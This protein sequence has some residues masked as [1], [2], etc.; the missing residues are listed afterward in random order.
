MTQC[1]G[2]IPFLA[3]MPERRYNKEKEPDGE[4]SD[5]NER[6]GLWA[7]FTESRAFLPCA[8][9]A[10][11]ILAGGVSVLYRLSLQFASDTLGH[12]LTFI[13]KNAGWTAVWFLVLIA[14]AGLTSLLVRRQPLIGGSGIPQLECELHGKIKSSWISVLLCKFAGGFLCMLGGLSL[15][16]EGPSIQ[17][18]AM[19]GKGFSRFLRRGGEEERVLISCGASAGLAAAFHAPAAGVLFCLEELHHTFT[20]RL[21]LPLMTAVLSA[22]LLSVQVFGV[23]PVFQFAPQTDFTPVLYLLVVPLGLLLG[24]L[25]A[26]YNAATMAVVRFLQDKSGLPVFV[27]LLIPF[28]M[29]GILALCAPSLLGS[30]HNLVEQAAAGDYMLEILLLLLVGKFLFSLLSFGSGTPGGIFFPLLVLGALIGCSY[31]VCAVE[32]FGLEKDLIAAFLLLGMAGNFAAIVRAPFTGAILLFEMTGSVHTLL[33]L[34]AVSLI[35][36]ATADAL[37]SA[38][39]YDSLAARLNAGRRSEA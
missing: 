15:G 19:A 2:P 28:L 8:G 24:V 34:L 7:R 18:G 13:R 37:R 1:T 9:F 17:L 20:P 21:L 11:G 31:G 27:R 4:E 16:R 30:G 32:L 33:P 39:I 38:P 36:C 6:A 12:S 26:F 22:D 5:M 29:A 3:A 25:G 23:G 10:A 35:A 14:L